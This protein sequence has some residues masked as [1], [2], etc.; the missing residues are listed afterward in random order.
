MEWEV[1][2]NI[3][4]IKLSWRS[5]QKSCEFKKQNDQAQKK[6]FSFLVSLVWEFMNE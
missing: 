4:W 5:S 1:V 2:M 3:E 6:K